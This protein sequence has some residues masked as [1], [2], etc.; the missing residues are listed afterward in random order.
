MSIPDIVP[1]RRYLIIWVD[2]NGYETATKSLF[3]SQTRAE[4]KAIK[5]N[6]KYGIEFGYSYYVALVS[7]IQ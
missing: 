4:N 5:D 2:C 6:Q 7:L 3:N 1:E